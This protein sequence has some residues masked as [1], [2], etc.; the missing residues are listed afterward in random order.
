[1]EE[2]KLTFKDA[3]YGYAL[4]FNHDCQ[5]RDKCMHYRMGTLAPADLMAGQ[6]VYPVA[7]KDGTCRCFREI[8]LIQFAWGFSKLYHG[9]TSGQTTDARS[10]LRARLGR[11]MSAY[12]R[13]HHGERMLTPKQQQEVIDIIVSC[14]GSKDAK[15][16]HYVTQYDFT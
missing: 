11:G 2:K 5:L 3:P 9:M 13:Y 4:C 14:G 15:F 1:M 6:C 12:Y 10:T 16:D 7:W 8:R